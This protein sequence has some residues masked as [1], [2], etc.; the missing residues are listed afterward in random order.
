MAMKSKGLYYTPRHVLTNTLTA[1]TATKGKVVDSQGFNAVAFVI[2]ADW[3]GAT[4]Q[5]AEIVVTFSDGVSSTDLV[6]TLDKPYTFV[7]ET[8]K[9]SKA[10]PAKVISYIGGERFIEASFAL[11]KASATGVSMSCVAILDNP[12]LF[13]AK[14]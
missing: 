3:T 7:P 10:D 2:T 4:A 11:T 1:T 14:A 8:V 9:V 6:P 13:D 5:D 12:D